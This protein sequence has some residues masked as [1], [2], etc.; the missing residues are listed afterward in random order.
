MGVARIA[1]N[2][3]QLLCAEVVLAFA[4]GFKANGAQKKVCG[5]IEQPDERIKDV[6]KNDQ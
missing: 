5:T 1:E 4:C 2:V 3:F 6:I